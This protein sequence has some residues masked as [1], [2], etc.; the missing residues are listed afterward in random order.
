MMRIA[1]LCLVPLLVSAAELDIRVIYD[2]TSARP[3]FKEDWGYSAV[4]TFKGKRVLFDSGT[5]P[6]LFTQNLKRSGVE[7]SS[8][9]A[10][11]ISHEHPDHIGGIFAILRATKPT[12]SLNF[13]DSFPIAV[14][15]M[16]DAADFSPRRLVK[17]R[18]IV[19]G[20]FTTGLVQG[21]PSEQAL[22][23]ETSQG[24]VMMTGCSHP[25]IVKMIETA[26]QQ[27]NAKSIRLLIGGFHLFEMK[28]PDIVPIVAK[29]HQLGVKSVIPA[30]CSGDAAKK[31]LK[32]AYG[33]NYDTAGAGKRLDLE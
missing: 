23:I 11:V 25:G 16:A 19:P 22:L 15:E 21:S 4:V 27:R 29:M 6:D 32:E 8:L 10:T 31:L 9:D 20:V 5:K 1:L 26:L 13:L 18:E 30:H 28:E 7:A 3:G 33:K 12:M 2:N 17:P 24:L 14:F